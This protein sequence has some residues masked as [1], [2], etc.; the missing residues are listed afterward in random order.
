MNERMNERMNVNVQR[1]TLFHRLMGVMKTASRETLASE[2]SDIAGAVTTAAVN[3]HS[4]SPDGT[5]QHY[6]RHS[7]SPCR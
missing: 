3:G 2:H 7:P 1:P 4:V 6:H 5:S